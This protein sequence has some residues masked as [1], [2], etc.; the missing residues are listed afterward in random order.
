MQKVIEYIK[1]K[2]ITDT[3]MAMAYKMITENLDKQEDCILALFQ[4][5]YETNKMLA[6]EVVKQR[7]KAPKVILSSK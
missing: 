2:A 1:T 3:S 5:M 4:S 7:A 6:D